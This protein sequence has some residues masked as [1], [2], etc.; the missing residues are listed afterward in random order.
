MLVF[1]NGTLEYNIGE[2]NPSMDAN[3]NPI[4]SNFSTRS[5]KCNIETSTFDRSGN[6]GDGT[7]T[8]STY[9]IYV[10]MPSVPADWNPMNVRL[11]HKRKGLLG[12]FTVQRVEFYELTQTIV[13]WV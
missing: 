5:V 2:G 1:S 8:N 9:T 12:D 7:N 6:Y 11:T 13:L 3:G 4:R 10:D